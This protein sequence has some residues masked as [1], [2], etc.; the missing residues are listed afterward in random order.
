ML[1]NK[2][3]EVTAKLLLGDFLD[4]DWARLNELAGNMVSCRHW[5]CHFNPRFAPVTLIRVAQFFYKKN[6]RGVAKL[7]G[8][9]NFL[10]FGIEVPARLTIGPGLVL[11][12]PQGTVLGAQKI[13][14]NV[15]IFHQVTLGSKVA[16]FQ[17]NLDQRPNIQDG[18]TISAGAKVLGPVV[19]GKGATV[20]ANAVV[21]ED[22]PEGRTVVGIPAKVIG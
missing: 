3:P 19:L 17:Y 20:G 11:P 15:T 1:S 9:L 8:L 4:A 21:L 7:F 6:Y 10:I 14:A 13:G 22:V 16:D 18:V 2:N 5:R 12:H